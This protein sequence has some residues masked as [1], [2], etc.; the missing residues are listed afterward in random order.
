MI[1]LSTYIDLIYARGRRWIV[2]LG[3]VLRF[4][5]GSEEEPMMGFVLHPTIKF[6]VAGSFVPTA[7]IC[8]NTLNLPRP[9]PAIPLPQDQ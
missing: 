9:S 6:T 4:A 2:S 1:G 5:T 8:A 7:S 3:K